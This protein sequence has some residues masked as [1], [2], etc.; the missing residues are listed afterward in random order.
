MKE[1]L[2]L[3]STKLNTAKALCDSHIKYYTNY[4]QATKPP[5]Q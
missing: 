3:V 4:L 1:Q 2:S 5:T